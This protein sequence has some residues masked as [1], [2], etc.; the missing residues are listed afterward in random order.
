[1]KNTVS[2]RIL[3]ST[4]C[5]YHLWVHLVINRIVYQPCRCRDVVFQGHRI[6]IG[7][8]AFHRKIKESTQDIVPV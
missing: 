2:R 3:I 6:H 1:M 4:G 5:S 7:R 8:I